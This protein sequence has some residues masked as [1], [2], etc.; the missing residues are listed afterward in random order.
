MSFI[1]D[2]NKIQLV[3][4]SLYS[5]VAEKT[6]AMGKAGWIPKAENQQR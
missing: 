4:N 6:E 5:S 2:E 3:M 1:L